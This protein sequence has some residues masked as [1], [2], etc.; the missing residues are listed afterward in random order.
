M[1]YIQDSDVTDKV[2]NVFDLTDCI[3]ESDLAVNDIAA[4]RG[5]LDADDISVDGSGYVT[6]YKLKRYA[7]VFVCM[8]VCQDK[9]GLNNNDLPVEIEKYAVKYKM[10]KEELDGI[11]GQITAEMITG[12]VDEIADRATSH[13]LFRG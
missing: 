6:S 10:Y 13:R 8:R 11:D 9:M 3:V 12:T 7:I 4:R 2:V 1:P 5:V